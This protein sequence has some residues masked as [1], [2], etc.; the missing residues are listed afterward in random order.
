MS[1]SGNPADSPKDKLRFKVG[2]T[3]DSELL[4][5]DEVNYIISENDTERLQVKAYIDA[6]LPK[7][8]KLSKSEDSGDVSVDY[9]SWFEYLQKAY[10]DIINSARKG[11]VKAPR[12]ATTNTEPFFKRNDAFGE[13]NSL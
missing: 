12:S 9:G 3:N 7:V 8:A 4:T 6:I 5:D 1:Y 10:E 11:A 2:D 13:M